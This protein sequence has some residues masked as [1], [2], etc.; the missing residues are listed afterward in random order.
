VIK[1]RREFLSTDADAIGTRVLLARFHP[2]ADKR[3]VVVVA[4]VVCGPDGAS[5]QA[6]PPT[7]AFSASDSLVRK[8]RY[9]IEHAAPNPFE[10]LRKLRS[11][12]WSF[13]EFN[14]LEEK[15]SQA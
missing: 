10:S 1:V 12:F 2:L 9:L 14:P 8:L 4:L 13:T 3:Q 5:L 11:Q 7:G 6:P 15:E